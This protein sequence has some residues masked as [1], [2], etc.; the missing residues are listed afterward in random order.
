MEQDV[1]W[2]SRILGILALAIGLGAFGAQHWRLPT[3]LFVTALIV[4]GLLVLCAILTLPSVS[5]RI[6]KHPPALQDDRPPNF[7]SEIYEANDMLRFQQLTTQENVE[8][9]IERVFDKL[10]PWS[11][12]AAT[13]FRP[14]NLPETYDSYARREAWYNN[15]SEGRDANL[16]YVLE[17]LG[18]GSEPKPVFDPWMETLKEHLDRLVQVIS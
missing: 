2:E 3:W 4:A 1:P 13:A 5:W 7:V 15:S 12:S 8:D 17:S 18:R 11:A 9:W 14:F 16:K 10:L 6:A